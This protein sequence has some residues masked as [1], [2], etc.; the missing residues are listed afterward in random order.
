M[1]NSSELASPLETVSARCWPSRS[2]SSKMATQLR[3]MKDAEGYSILK[4]R[5]M[6]DALSHLTPMQQNSGIEIQ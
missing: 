4:L 3:V 6:K 1:T 2:L 5:V